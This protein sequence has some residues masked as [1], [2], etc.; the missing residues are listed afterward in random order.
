M[1]TA[2]TTALVVVFFVSIAATVAA[3]VAN[4]RAYA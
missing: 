1:I 3:N 2:I 4:V